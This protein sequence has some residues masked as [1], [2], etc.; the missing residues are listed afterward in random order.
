AD[1]DLTAFGDEPAE[2]ALAAFTH[3]GILDV[4]A[5][6]DSA[7]VDAAAFAHVTLHGNHDKLIQRQMFG[8]GGIIDDTAFGDV[9]GAVLS[10][11]GDGAEPADAAFDNTAILQAKLFGDD[12][13]VSAAAFARVEVH[14]PTR[15]SGGP[16]VNGAVVVQSKL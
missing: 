8:D 9:D 13:F 7:E 2:S 16:A 12:V 3:L 14:G 10:A 6:G 5:F 15:T 4:T 1:I 11:F